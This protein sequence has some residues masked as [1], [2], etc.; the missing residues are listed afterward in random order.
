MRNLTLLVLGGLLLLTGQSCVT[1]NQGEVG[2]RRVRGVLDSTVLYE[3]RTGIN[4]FNT[5]VF[6]IS[7]Q[8]INERVNL[9]LPSKE[10]LTIQSEISILYR[11]VPA[12]ASDLFR[13]VGRNYER[14]LIDP[15][16]RS[17]AADVSARFFAK[18]LHSGQRSEIER[19][20]EERMNSILE[21]R[22][23]IIENVLMKSIQ[24]PEGLTLAIEE[25]LKAEQEAQRR[26]FITQQEKADAERR[27]IQAEGERDASILAAEAEKRTL[28]LRAEA[29][30]NATKIQA[31][32]E[33]H[34]IEVKASAEAKSNELLSKYVSESV[35]KYRGIEAMLE[36]AG[37]PS[38]KLLINPGG[39]SLL[40]LPPEF[41]KEL[42]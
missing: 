26:I 3:G 25:K 39:M 1:I 20:I 2:V 33:A 19:E 29:K 23:I 42:E 21:P 35:L 8:T 17:A 24:L 30:A 18:D 34:A 31:D 7:T 9:P 6:K 5:T 41:W 28:E 22:G 12:K 4:I 37:S 16:F 13:E 27:V 11:V 40:G 38:S 10:G 15:V 36:L 32:A 14:E